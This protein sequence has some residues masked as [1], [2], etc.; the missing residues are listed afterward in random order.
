MCT[1]EMEVEAVGG[2]MV[3]VEERSRQVEVVLATVTPL[4]ARVLHIQC[5]QA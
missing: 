3:G 1:E 2:I 4:S 5:I